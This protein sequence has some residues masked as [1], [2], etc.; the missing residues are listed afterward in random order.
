MAGA[1]CRQL[2]M[3]RQYQES[4]FSTLAVGREKS[5]KKFEGEVGS[6]EAE[7]HEEREQKHEM[8]ME[9]VRKGRGQRVFTESNC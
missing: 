6:L 8:R 2:F 7:L 1:L 4:D 3:M 9:K 5:R